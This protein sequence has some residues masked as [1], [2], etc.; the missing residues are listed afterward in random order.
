MTTLLEREVQR[1]AENQHNELTTSLVTGVGVVDIGGDGG[2][3]V[4]PR[5]GAARG[6]VA[7]T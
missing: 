2:E 4:G 7:V 6:G 1:S 3:R 5:V